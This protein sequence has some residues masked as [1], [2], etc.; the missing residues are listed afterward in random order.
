M[1]DIIRAYLEYLEKERNYSPLT[2]RSYAEDL[3]QFTGFLRQ[4]RHQSFSAV[5]KNILRDYQRS[6]VERGLS[7]KS[8][9]RKLAC[10]RSFFKYLRRQNLIDANPALTLV[11]PRLE[12]PLPVFLDERTT[13]DLL[14]VPDQSTDAGKRDA[15]LLETLYSTGIRLSELIGLSVRDMDSAQGT[16]KVRGKGRKERIVPIGKRA[17]G[18]IRGYLA[19]RAGEHPGGAS[20]LFAL[21]GGKRLYPMAVHRLL[22]KYIAAVSEIQK[23]S[24]HVIRH[25]FA[26]HLLNRGADLRAVKELLGHESLSTTQVYTHVSTERMKKIYRQSHPKA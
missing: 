3:N 2:V 5:R 6:M 13:E 23:K 21:P 14:Q 16:I 18:A 4:R 19:T 17:I 7:T 22:Q 20:P 8:I 26:T 1:Q 24:P 10:L 15:A 11:S 12:R 9:T 25:T